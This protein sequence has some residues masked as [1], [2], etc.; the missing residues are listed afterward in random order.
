[1]TVVQL[2]RKNGVAGAV[3]LDGGILAWSSRINPS[4]PRY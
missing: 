1:M 2:L 3:N 4:V